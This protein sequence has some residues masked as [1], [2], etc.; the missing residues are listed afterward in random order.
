MGKAKW[1]VFTAGS[2]RLQSWAITI[3]TIILINFSLSQ[4]L[5]QRELELRDERIEDILRIQDTRTPHNSRLL[6]YL[7]DK[8]PAVREKATVAF[9]SIQDT[10]VLHLLVTNLLDSEEKV[11]Y[12]AVFAI[13]QTATQL[14][15]KGKENFQHDLIWI[16]HDQLQRKNPL[17]AEKLIEEIGKFGTEDALKDLM[18]RFGA[19]RDNNSN[20]SVVMSIARFA[21]RGVV[22]QEATLYLISLVKQDEKVPWQVLYA[23]Q[24]IGNNPDIKNNLAD[25][26]PVYRHPDPLARMYAATLFGKLKDEAA[27][28]ALKQLAEYDT[29]WRVRVNALKALSNFSINTKVEIVETFRRSFLDK[30]EY[31]G[32]T[33]IEVL[34]NTGLQEVGGVKSIAETFEKLKEISLNSKGDYLWQYQAAA[35]Y[36]LAR[37]IGADAW[38][39]INISE[40]QENLLQA[41]LLKALG[42]TGDIR[43]QATLESYLT[44]D[45]PMLQRSA[46]EALDILTHKNQNDSVRV[47]K[48]YQTCLQFLQSDDVAVVT[49]IAEILTDSIFQRPQSVQPLIEKLQT[50]RVP[51]DIEAMQAICNTLGA[52]KDKRAIEVLE[53][54]MDTPDRSIALSAASALETITGKNYRKNLPEWIQPL[55]TDFDFKYFHALPE[56]INVTMETTRGTIRMDLYKDIAP[57]T[58][59]SFLKL[60]TERGYYRGL[61]FH[62]VVPNFVIQGGDPRGDGWGGPGYTIRSEFS[63]LSYETGTLGMASAG[64]DTE[65][66]QFF[67]TQSPQPHLDGKYTIFG[68]VTSGMEAVNKIRSDDRILDVK[69]GE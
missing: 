30:V 19:N 50:M 16:R 65:G 10:S 11:Q 6:E 34:G 24:R 57:F 41:A 54:V 18:L 8:D 15:R 22:R 64:K 25:L 36:T 4:T 32:L 55:Y 60:A 39:Y 58:V 26:L 67:I 51:D 38:Q 44:S 42:E 1:S 46:I 40:R 56:T 47:E 12:A 23:L 29:D 21:I 13:C 53:D 49:F 5:S 33:A 63:S 48:T 9:G 31:I 59:M 37:L 2:P 28:D 45:I 7:S 20:I 62:R 61:Y 35:S 43:V 52:L 17:A 27:I 68:K 14:S 3:L 69:M 66:S